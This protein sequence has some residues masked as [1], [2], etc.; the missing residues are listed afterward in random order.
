MFLLLF[1]FFVEYNVLF[2][3]S[4]HLNKFISHYIITIVSL[5]IHVNNTKKTTTTTT[6]KNQKDEVYLLIVK[7]LINIREINFL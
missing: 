1:K 7:F 3:L 4:L 5:M 2:T 6:K